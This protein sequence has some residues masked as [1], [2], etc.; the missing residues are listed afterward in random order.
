MCAGGGYYCQTCWSQPKY[1]FQWTVA[2]KC[3]QLSGW[4]CA[5]NGCPYDK[6]RMAG[7]ITFNDKTNPKGS[8]VMNARMPSGKTANVLSAIKVVNTIRLGEC[9]MTDEDVRRHGGLGEALKKTIGADNDRYYRYFD[10]LRRVAK[11][12]EIKP[13][14]LAGHDCPHFEIC[15]GPNDVTL[16]TKDFDGRGFVVYDV[17]KLFNYEEPPDLSDAAWKAIVQTVLSAWSVAEAGVIHPD[18]LNRWTKC[19]KKTLKSLRNWT[20]IRSTGCH[21]PVDD[22]KLGKPASREYKE[23]AARPFDDF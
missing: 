10:Q 5:A 2:R 6:K 21:P 11:E 3:G 18:L 7:L 20:Y 23:W 19:S 13:P 16:T 1:D 22:K 8:F 15:D 9:A 17:G 14:N 12:G 4:F